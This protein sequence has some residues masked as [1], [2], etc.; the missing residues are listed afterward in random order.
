MKPEELDELLHIGERRNVE[1]K[2]PGTL[3]K[4]KDK[5]VKAAIA[6]ANLRIESQQVV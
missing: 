5:I 4:Y 1:F 3:K 6:L 2:A